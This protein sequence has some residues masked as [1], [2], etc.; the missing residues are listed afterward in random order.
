VEITNISSHGITLDLDIYDA[1]MLAHALRACYLDINGMR[2]EPKDYG[3]P[4]SQQVPEWL[5]NL[6]EGWANTLDATAYAAYLHDLVRHDPE[7]NLANWRTERLDPGEEP[8]GLSSHR[9]VDRPQGQQ[10]IAKEA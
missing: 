1:L 9:K 4:H 8:N 10:Q 3:F 2:T 5:A 6:F 7:E